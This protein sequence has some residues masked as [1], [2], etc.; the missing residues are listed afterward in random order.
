MKN[1][2]FTFG[3][4]LGVLCAARAQAKV[5][6]QQV[7]ISSNVGE[8]H[9]GYAHNTPDQNQYI[10]CQVAPG[11]AYCYLLDAAGTYRACA[12][13]DSGLMTAAAAVTSSAELIMFWDDNGGCRQLDTFNYSYTPPKVPK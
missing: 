11:W 8:G 9:V 10:G 4:F 6:G 3:L 2:V 7:V 1:F 13:A 5:H 12:T